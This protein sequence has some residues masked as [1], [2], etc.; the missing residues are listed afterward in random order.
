[1]LGSPLAGLVATSILYK[2]NHQH[3]PMQLCH[4]KLPKITSYTLIVI[5]TSTCPVLMHL[6]YNKKI[7]EICIINLKRSLA[8]LFKLLE[9]LSKSKCHTM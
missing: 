2:R 4:C 6:M 3:M 1:M 9:F 8:P 5:H 7:I